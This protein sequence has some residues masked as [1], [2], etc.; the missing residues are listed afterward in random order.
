MPRVCDY[1]GSHYRTEFWETHHRAYEDAVERIAMGKMLPAHGKR[2]IEI[3]AGFGRL[4]ELYSGYE[5]IILVDY[6]RTQLEE[7][8]KY[9]GHDDRITYV[10]AD[11]YNMPFEDNLFDTLAMVRVMHHLV[12]VPAALAEIQRIIQPQG[13]AVI[14]HAS[15][16]NLKAIFRWFFGLQQWSPFDPEPVEFV[17]LNFNFH[18]TWMRRQFEAAGLHVTK[19]RTLS[20]YRINALKRLL[21]TSM[22]VMLDS[23]AQPT[24]NL[25]QLTP[26]IFLQARAVKA[27]SPRPAGLFRCPSCKSAALA[28]TEQPA[29]AEYILTCHIC[30]LGWQYK[31]GIYDF[32][33]PVK[34]PDTAR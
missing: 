32:K 5:Q 9:L 17:E 7:A 10:V 23:W 4:V 6:A 14:E 27:D 21:P 3:G 33:S 22:L 1:E 26:S 15:K 20:H 18:P 31:N 2:L 24:G 16:F 12:D 25:W 19:I 13:I 11:V 30:Q 29:H 34:A 8:Q 28:I